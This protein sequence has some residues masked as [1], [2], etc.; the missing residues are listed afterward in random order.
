M[1]R[2]YSVGHYRINKYEVE[3]MEKIKFKDV[4]WPLKTAVVAIWIIGIAWILV[5]LLGFAG[6]VF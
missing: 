1:Y 2:R 3:K 6:Y 4:S 5:F